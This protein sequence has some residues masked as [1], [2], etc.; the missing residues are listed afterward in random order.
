MRG[1]RQLTS[2]CCLIS[3]RAHQTS[4]IV[5]CVYDPF[6]GVRA[7]LMPRYLCSQ[8][9]VLLP[10]PLLPTK[11][12]L[13]APLLGSS[14]T[15]VAHTPCAKRH[16]VPWPYNEYRARSNDN[17]ESNVKKTSP[18]AVLKNGKSVF[19]KSSCDN[20]GASSRATPQLI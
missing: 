13:I 16:I 17:T 6:H 12:M 20:T 15:N 8:H 14:G 10:S 1:L 2:H 9:F 3:E 18:P 5:R 11:S 7:R 4:P 19:A